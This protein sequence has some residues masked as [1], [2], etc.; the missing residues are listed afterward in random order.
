MLFPP[1]ASSQGSRTSKANVV[2]E[3][4]DSCDHSINPFE[5]LMNIEEEHDTSEGVGETR[6]A[7]IGTGESKKEVPL[8]TLEDDPFDELWWFKHFVIVR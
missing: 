7:N 8:K 1:A 6:H 5:A 2:P 4:H 3:I